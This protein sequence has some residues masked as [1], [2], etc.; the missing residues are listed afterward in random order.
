MS[1]TASSTATVHRSRLL[2]AL[3][4]VEYQF[5]PAGA[6]PPEDAAYGHQRHSA[7]V[8][9]S[10]QAFPAKSCEGDAV[11]A[12]DD[13]PVAVY[14][15]DCLPMLIVDRHQRRVAAAHGGLRGVT[16]GIHIN[17]L[18]K[19]CEMG[20]VPDSL[21]LIIG[22]AIGPCCYELGQQVITDMQQQPALAPLRD[23]LPWSP[24]QPTNRLARRPQAVAQQSGVWFDL[25]ALAQRMAEAWGLASENVEQL[26]V[27]T[28]CAAEEHASYRRNTH[29]DGGYQQRYSWIRRVD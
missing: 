6:R 12:T 21:L 5:M 4:W 23:A 27:C 16:A 15:A 1:A 10:Q 19:L 20:A 9:S 11:I 26:S 7:T 22:P 25:P 13:R 14:T 8:L 18:N 17:V 3:P 2:D 24:Q 28:Y 29:F